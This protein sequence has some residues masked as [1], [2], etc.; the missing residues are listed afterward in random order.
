MDRLRVALAR[1]TG[2]GYVVYTIIVLPQMISEAAGRV[3]AWYPVVGGLLAFGPGVAL[4]AVS[5]VRRWH[6]AIAAAAI[7]CAVG[8]LG[9]AVLW[10][11]VC[12][13]G[14]DTSPIWILDFVGLAGLAVVLVRPVL[15]AVAV[16]VVG[17][18]AGAAVAVWNVDGVDAWAAV[19]EALFGIVFTSLCI[20]LVRRVLQVGA[21][22][23]ESRADT[24]RAVA[25]NVANIELARVD[26]LIH[27]HVLSTFVAVAA[28]RDDARVPAQASEALVALD[29]LA[30]DDLAEADVPGPEL[31]ARLRAVIGGISSDLP[32]TVEVAADAP[33]CPAE[34]VAALAEAAAEAVR[35]SAAHAGPDAETAV[36]IGVRADLVQV[37]VTDDGV[38]FD[39]EAVGDDRLGLALSIRHR[40]GALVGGET[41]VMSTPGRGSTVRLWWTPESREDHA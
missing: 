24:E 33:S 1:L 27:D 8:A 26:A 3:P 14:S 38:G 4:F 11:L 21:D 25:R 39:P 13:S 30:A 10:L 29:R 17:K 23:D 9:A 22:L 37:V 28:D 20:L 2:A 36:Y 40:V 31:V 41:A 12:E 32:V 18:L 7:S 6:A 34:V 19:E 15:E 5:V 35:N 16:L